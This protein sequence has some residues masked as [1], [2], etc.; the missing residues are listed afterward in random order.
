M[1]SIKILLGGK[2]IQRPS[3]PP[4]DDPVVPRSRV[5]GRNLT[6]SARRNVP[7]PEKKRSKRRDEDEVREKRSK[8]VHDRPLEPPDE[9]E[10]VDED[11]DLGQDA[12]D[13]HLMDEDD[14]G[15][16]AAQ[17]D[18]RARKGKGKKKKKKTVDDSWRLTGAMLAGGPMIPELI[19]S[20]GGH[21]AVDVWERNELRQAMNSE[22]VRVK[23]EVGE[24][25]A[26]KD[27]K[28]M[29]WRHISRHIIIIINPNPIPAKLHPT[30]DNPWHRLGD[31]HRHHILLTTGKH[32][33]VNPQTRPLH[34]SLR[35]RRHQLHPLRRDKRKKPG[36]SKIPDEGVITEEMLDVEVEEPEQVTEEL[37]PDNSKT[38]PEVS[39]DVVV[40]PDAETVNVALSMWTELLKKFVNPNVVVE[41]PEKG[42]TVAEPVL[43][44]REGG[45]KTCP[46]EVDEQP[47]KPPL[48]KPIVSKKSA[49]EVEPN[50][51][52]SKVDEQPR[53]APLRKPSLSK[54]AAKGIVIK[55][56]VPEKAKTTGAYSEA[57]DRDKGKTVVVSGEIAGGKCTMN[58]CILLL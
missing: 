24:K 47:K 49:K 8:L 23:R 1:N 28:L 39:G 5:D 42:G 58:C 53:K 52:T 3:N 17:A 21:V 13:R 38:C 44:T 51:S 36:K 55:E 57:R 22:L 45:Q 31:A 41:P 26:R 32:P 11:E 34:S 7:P 6:A 48:K 12:G 46:S 16:T 43:D 18:E 54:K 30:K 9:D 2:K 15:D 19:P 20:F 37:M 4:E 29:M 27:Q 35:S 33:I 10:A 40:Q 14:E 50:T 25:M 56:P